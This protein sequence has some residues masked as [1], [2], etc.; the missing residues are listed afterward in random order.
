MLRRK[1][2]NRRKSERAW[3]LRLP[4][5]NWRRLGL[6]FGGIA[7]VALAL[8]AL[9]LLLDQ[10]IERIVITGRLQRVSALDIEKAVRAHLH[11]AGLVRVDLDEISGGLR[12]LP[13]IDAVAVQRAWPRGLK[14]D[15]R[16]QSAI[17]RW[18]DAGLINARGELFTSEA[19]FVPPELP[20]LTGPDGSEAE[21]AARYLTMQGRLVEA[22]ARLVA[23]ELDARGAWTLTLDN[24]VVVRL[25]REQLD[26]RFERFASAAVR[27]VS[28]RASDITYVDMRYANGFA[29]GWKS[30]G[31]HLASSQAAGGHSHG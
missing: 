24:N 13:W 11:G 22:G 29:V 3:R 14:V 21:V 4:Q 30:G 31:T 23:L 5:L 19:R 12:A 26:E 28:E 6:S 17:A 7:V 1:R 10:P 27:L 25:G 16:E 2:N 9:G 18:D 15:V 20:K 8:L